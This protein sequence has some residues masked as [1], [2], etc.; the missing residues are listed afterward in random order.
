MR[1]SA[2]GVDA[3]SLADVGSLPDWLL[4]WLA[5]LL[6]EVERPGKWPA[7]LAEGYTAQIPKDGPPGLLNSRPLTVL[8]RVY[9]LWGGIRL[10]D[11]IA[12]QETCVQPSAFG[13][14]PARSA[15]DG[16]AV[17]QVLLELC[18]L[19]RWA[20]AGMSIDYVKCFD[21]ILQA[22][23]L[24]LALELGMDPGTCRALRAMYEQLRRAFKV[25]GA[26]GS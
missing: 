17:T 8:S 22:V 5:S 4:D 18:R 24:A 19:N 1:P 11:A 14:R 25:A 13:I 20:V 16:A 7:C 23:V 9:R 2:L 15:V 3:W 10:V 21:L 12:W 26:L 6:R